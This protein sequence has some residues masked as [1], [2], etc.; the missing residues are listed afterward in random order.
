MVYCYSGKQYHLL[1]TPSSLPPQMS[2]LCRRLD[3][4]WEENQGSVVLF[5]WVQFL[6]EEALDFLNIQSPLE[7]IRVGSKAGVERR[8]AEVATTGTV[9]DRRLLLS[10]Q[11]H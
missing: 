1:P 7:I 10:G 8:K 9:C 2:S 4:L 5:T 3:D 6:K 11:L